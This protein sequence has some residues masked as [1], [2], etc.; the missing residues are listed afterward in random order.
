MI[1]D[2]ELIRHDEALKVSLEG[3]HGGGT[4]VN[5]LVDLHD[6]NDLHGENEPIWYIIKA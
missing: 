6:E 5:E 2:V 1:D 3:E 4:Q